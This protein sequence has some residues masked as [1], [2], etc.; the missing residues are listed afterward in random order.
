[1]TKELPRIT[2]KKIITV[3]EKAGFIL[4]RQSGSH[5]IYK[6]SHGRRVTV[7]YHSGKIL[8]PKVLKSILRDAEIAGEEL[9]R[10]L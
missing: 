3:L 9:K 4:V 5:K 8:H 1:M 2:A 10:L 7:P 6:N